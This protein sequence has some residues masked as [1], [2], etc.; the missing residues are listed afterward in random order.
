MQPAKVYQFCLLNNMLFPTLSSFIN[1]FIC[2]E[3]QIQG[4][5][6]F[7]EKKANQIKLFDFQLVQRSK[8]KYQF[9]VCL[10]IPLEKVL[11]QR[12]INARYECSIPRCSG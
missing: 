12:I 10:K 1:D 5:V 3:K 4:N 11:S 6:V 2:S 9:Y 7:A 8:S